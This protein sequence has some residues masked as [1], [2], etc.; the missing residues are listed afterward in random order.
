MF[1]G[2]ITQDKVFAPHSCQE[3]QMCQPIYLNVKSFSQFQ[4]V[5]PF[6]PV[7]V[8]LYS[9]E[10]HVNQ[11]PCHKLFKIPQNVCLYLFLL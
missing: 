1:E 10:S 3:S 7:L 6:Q 11:V 5:T 4:S 2:E 9:S 8:R